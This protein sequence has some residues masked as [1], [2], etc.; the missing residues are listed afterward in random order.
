M[1][2]WKGRPY[3]AILGGKEEDRFTNYLAE[4]LQDKEVL[5]S[6]CG[7]FLRSQ[8]GFE[9][10]PDSGLNARTQVI[11]PDGRPDLAIRGNSTYLLIEAKV[12]SW[13]HEDQLQSYAEALDRW[14]RENPTGKACLFVLVPERQV[15][16]TLAVARQQL[17]SP[18]LERWTPRAVSWEQVA[19]FLE[20]LADGVDD[21]NLG[22]HLRDFKELVN[23]RFGTAARPFLAEEASIL[24]DSLV[25]NALERVLNVVDRVV[26]SL[27]DR[28]VKLGNKGVTNEDYI[29]YKLVLGDREW[30]YGLWISPWSRL[31]ESPT[32]LQLPGVANK[33]MDNIPGGLPNPLQFEVDS[34]LREWVVPLVHREGVELDKLAEEHFGII[35]RYM[36][37]V[38]ESGTKR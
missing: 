11:V 19:S 12:S 28:G 16:A 3:L 26:T 15:G 6:F 38:Q 24:Q 8:C 35:W 30:W 13:L 21:R 33:S 29:G 14:Q 10:D 2:P 18:A 37:E 17:S 36:T 34:D 27:S 32:F 20:S 7:R 22:V 23:Y 9:L 5:A 4:L 25:A 1:S 31:G